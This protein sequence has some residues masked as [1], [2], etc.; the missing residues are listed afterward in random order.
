[1]KSFLEYLKEYEKKQLE[2]D[3][4]MDANVGSEANGEVVSQDAAAA[5][6]KISDV[7]KPDAITG[8]TDHSVLGVKSKKKCGNG[9][10][11]GKDDFYIPQNVLSGEVQRRIDVQP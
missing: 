2:E 4:V 8:L 5:S 11:F 1:M 10:F 6:I 7:S 9:G 3:A